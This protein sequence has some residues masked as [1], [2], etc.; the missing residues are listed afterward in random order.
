MAELVRKTQCAQR[1]NGVREERMRPIE[2]MNEPFAIGNVRPACRLDRAGT[3]ERQLVKS[4]SHRSPPECAFTHEP[5][6]IPVGAD[7]VEP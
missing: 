1:A 7:V 6:E 3:F 5:P 2:R 4:R